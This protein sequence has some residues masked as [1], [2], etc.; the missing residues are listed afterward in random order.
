MVS[1]VL[2]SQFRLS[3]LPNFLQFFTLEVK[4]CQAGY[5]AILILVD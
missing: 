2:V 1:S 3:E 5:L 4:S